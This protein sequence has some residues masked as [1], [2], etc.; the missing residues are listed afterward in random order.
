MGS[1][2]EE[3]IKNFTDLDIWKLALELAVLIYKE[4]AGFPKSEKFG[5]TDQIRRSVNSV[6]A[7]IA[8]GFGRF[9]YREFIKF[10]LN[11]R[12]SL[13]ETKHW[14]ILSKELGYSTERVT[15]ELI[16]KIERLN[17]KVN[18]T[19]TVTEKQIVKEGNN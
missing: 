3:M 15:S 13:Q 5:I 17:V 19:I 11:A 6:G 9:H 7:N 8:E 4:T 2:I 18:N 10:L 16:L 12:G 1:R 14:L